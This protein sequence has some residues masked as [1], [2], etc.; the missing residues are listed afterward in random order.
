MVAIDQP[1]YWAVVPAAGIGQ[2]MQADR[3]KQYLLLG[4]GWCVLE[5]TL[6]R[7][8][9]QPWIACIV[10]ALAEQDAYWPVLAG[11]FQARVQTVV[12]GVE[13]SDSVL[14]ALN[15]LNTVADGQDWVLVHDAARPCVHA[16]D[17]QRLQRAL[18]THSVGGLLGVPV[19]DTMK[20]VQAGTVLATVPRAGLWHAYTPQMFR[21][22][23]LRT[24]LLAAKAVQVAVTDEA[25]AMERMGWM[26]VMIEGRRDNLKITQPQDLA[27]A[28]YYLQ[29][30]LREENEE[31]KRQV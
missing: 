30:Q 25:S 8:L 12:G 26:P 14:N 1:R 17:I 11:K 18:K 2:R 10:V 27:L 21:L 19:T 24:A 9:E 4:N 13:R 31:N 20:Q 6:L 29:Q 15:Y 16:Q 28:D 5:Q 7:L 23:P 3:P 22:Q